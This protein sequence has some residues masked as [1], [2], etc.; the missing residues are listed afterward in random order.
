[1]TGVLL[2]CARWA[3]MLLVV[4][5]VVGLAGGLLWPEGVARLAGYIWAYV[6]ALLFLAVLRLGPAGVRAGLR[7]M[8]GALVA[9]FAL[10]LALPLIAVLG[11]RWTGFEGPLALGLVLTLAA[12]P[13]TGTPNMTLLA[14]GDEAAALRALVLGTAL[15]PLTV[16]PVFL[17]VPAFGDPATVAEVVLRLLGLISVAGGVALALRGAGIVQP[18]HLPAFDGVA[19]LLLVVIVVALMGAAGPTLLTARGW[20]L[21]ALAFAL[22]LGMNL[23]AA[24][25]ARRRG[26]DPVAAGI[27]AGNRN[28][29][30]FLGA[31]P[32]AV[33]PGLLPW[34]GVYQIPMYLAPVIL[35]PLY[36]A[37]GWSPTASRQ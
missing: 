27:A 31:I 36:R 6:V 11:F 4:G 18:R 15:L 24:W 13:I 32:A 34:I 7:G 16:V 35:P 21:L 30:L 3:R 28:I 17:A 12:A 37:L 29:A 25:V 33:V 10:Q 5:L 26:A 20:A 19:A 22:S 9:V 8:G 14:G 23:G 1:M 2:A